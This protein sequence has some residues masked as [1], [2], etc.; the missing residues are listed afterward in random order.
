M[1]DV[2]TRVLLCVRRPRAGCD[3]ARRWP[4]CEGVELGQVLDRLLLLL[5]LLLLLGSIRVVPVRRRLRSSLVARILHLWLLLLLLWDRPAGSVRTSD[6]AGELLAERARGLERS[7][8][9]CACYLRLLST[10]ILRL[11]LGIVSPSCSPSRIVSCLLWLLKP[12]SISRLLWLLLMLLL[13]CINILILIRG[14][15]RGGRCS[16]GAQPRSEPCAL[17][18][19]V[20]GGVEVREAAEGVVRVVDEGIVG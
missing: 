5:L 15:R 16:P 11:C 14:G 12:S 3:L 18:G 2:L 20:V 6:L 19:I 9:S 10:I 13:T 7:A 4:W 8:C 1:L 17:A